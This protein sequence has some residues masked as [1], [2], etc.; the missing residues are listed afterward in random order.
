MSNINIVVQPAFRSSEKRK[1]KALRQSVQS[2]SFSSPPY[3]PEEP[4]F[5]PDFYSSSISSSVVKR[6]LLN[7]DRRSSP[8]QQPP[9]ANAVGGTP[10][11]ASQ[12][13]TNA[14]AAADRVGSYESNNG[15]FGYSCKN[16]ASVASPLRRINGG[17]EMLRG[18]NATL[19][20]LSSA[21]LGDGATNKQLHN[22]KKRLRY[23]PQ[24]GIQCSPK[25]LSASSVDGSCGSSSSHSTDDGTVHD[26]WIIDDAKVACTER[27][28]GIDAAF[29]PSF[30]IAFH[31]SKALNKFE[32]P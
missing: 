18:L 11:F 4:P 12:Q 8:H 14:F 26:D 3:S 29:E 9:T 16:D 31:E 7:N 21:S 30:S 19:P 10:L 15:L 13:N 2:F 25:I 5:S 28:N 17:S 27:T 1:A 6:Y 20:L 22:V 23:T 32:E 24:L